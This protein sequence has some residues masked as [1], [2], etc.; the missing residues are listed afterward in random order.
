MQSGSAPK[1]VK[2]A[3]DFGPLL[4]FFAAYK[5]SGL[6]AATLILMLATAIAVTLGFWATRRIA[7]VPLVTLGFVAIL[8]GLT[9]WFKDETFIKMKPT[10]VQLLFALILFGGLVFKRPTLK[11][12]LGEALQMTETGW[13]QLSLRFALFFTGMAVLNEIVWRSF[14]TDLWVDFKVFGILGLTLLFGIAQA[15]MMR[16][17]TIAGK[18]EIKS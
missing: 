2:P 12:V 7:A 1:W 13:R 17:H 11:Y 16:R 5:L 8:G 18:T 9:L 3:V 4:A 15:P 14:P 6:M 10:I